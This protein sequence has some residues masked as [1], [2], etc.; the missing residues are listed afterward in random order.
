MIPS[1]RSSAPDCSPPVIMWAV[2]SANGK[3]A[4]PGISPNRTCAIRRFLEMPIN[5]PP[6]SGRAELQRKEWA[7][8]RKMGFSLR[9]VEIRLA[10]REL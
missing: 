8:S 5:T 6:G 3:I 7:I 4:T 2:V 10:N 9:K 1:A